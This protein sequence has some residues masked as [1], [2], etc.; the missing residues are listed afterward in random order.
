MVTAGLSKNSNNRIRRIADVGVDEPV[1]ISLYVSLDPAEFP[2]ARERDAQFDSINHE[3]RTQH[4][5]D[6]L[7]H[8]SKRSLEEDIDRIDRW[9]RTSLDA[10]GIRGVAVFACAAADLFE[11]I[12]TSGSLPAAVHVARTAH[13]GP[14]VTTV[15]ARDW[16]V[17]VVDRR[18]ERVLRGDQDGLT[19]ILKFSDDVHGQH[20]QGGWSQARY[21]RSVEQEAKDH[22]R[23]A[24][25]RLFT[26]YKRLPFARLLLACPNELRP[27]VEAHLHPYV[28]ERLAGH[29]DADLG[30]H[31]VTEITE[32]A[33]PVIEGD[34]RRREAEVV[35]QLSESLGRGERA[36]AGLDDVLRAL[37]EKR[38]ETLLLAPGFAATGAVCTQCGWLSASDETCPADGEPLERTEDIVDEAVR[39]ALMQSAD[40]HLI[41]YHEPDKALGGLVAALLRF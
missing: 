3:L 32:R 21:Q 13:L 37:N 29:I 14:L 24:C 36:A 6:S 30:Y 8:D 7:S 22:V 35:E 11:V 17:F 20:D 4:L 19:E 40:V 39:A 25:E 15:N 18:N 33:R 2:T 10:D 26:I 34:E 12:G 28:M 27:E 31:N 41:R 1:F 5:S 38:A 23:D 9:L 16:C